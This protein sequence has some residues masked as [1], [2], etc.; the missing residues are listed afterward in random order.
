MLQPAR[1][2]RWRSRAFLT[3]GARTKPADKPHPEIKALFEQAI[4]DLA[5]LGADIV[6]P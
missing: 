1:V 4:S 5:S 3:E 6:D 2:L